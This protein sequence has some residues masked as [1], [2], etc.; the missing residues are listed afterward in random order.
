MNNDNRLKVYRLLTKIPL[1]KVSTYGAIA[2]RLKMSPRL[3]GRILSQN[4]HP[5]LY[6]CYRVIRSDGS[7]GGYTIG[8]VNNEHSLAV[9]KKKLISDG[10]KFSGDR[11]LEQFILRTI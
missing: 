6:P 10:V 9:K 7:L 1:G 2:S 8:S 5:D 4:G 3:V 11:V